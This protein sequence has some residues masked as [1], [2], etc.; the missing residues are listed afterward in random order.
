MKK[1]F[2]MILFETKK[3]SSIVIYL[4]KY[5]HMLVPFFSAQEMNLFGTSLYHLLEH[6]IVIMRVFSI[7][8]TMKIKNG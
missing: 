4:M 3:Y 2:T 7:V 6:K 1:I 8:Q 5:V